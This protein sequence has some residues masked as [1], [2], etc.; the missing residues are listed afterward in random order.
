MDLKKLQKEIYQNKIDKNFNV[1]DVDLEFDLTRGEL[2]EAQ[3]AHQQKRSDLREELADVAIYLLGLA[4]ILKV[5]L[6]REIV[7]KVS[8]NKKR[9][10]KKIN[11]EQV[12]VD[13]QN[14]K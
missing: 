14:I 1:K 5:D 11:R 13:K 4:E 2:D 8:K 6:E 9:R 12:D 3:E 10:Y 7:E